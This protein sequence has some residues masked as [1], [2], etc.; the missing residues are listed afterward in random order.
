MVLMVITV[1]QTKAIAMLQMTYLWTTI[2]GYG[3]Y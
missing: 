1:K 2:L 3:P